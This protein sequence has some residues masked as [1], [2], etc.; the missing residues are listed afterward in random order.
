[1]DV[2]DIYGPNDPAYDPPRC[3]CLRDHALDCAQARYGDTD[4]ECECI[5]HDRE[6]EG[7]EEAWHDEMHA[8]APLQ[9]PE[10]K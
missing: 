9:Q 1:M 2:F 10:R 5:C 8:P 4:E 7:W 3:A 6:P